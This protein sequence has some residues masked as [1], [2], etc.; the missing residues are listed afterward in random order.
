MNV[1]RD[2][3]ICSREARRG[4]LA[5]LALAAGLAAPEAAVAADP[6]RIIAPERTIVPGDAGIPPAAGAPL[7]LDLDL[8]A[9]GDDVVVFAG[10]DGYGGAFLDITADGTLYAAHTVE[11]GAGSEIRVLRSFDGGTTWA[12]WTSL[13]QP[14]TIHL[15]DF[16]IAEGAVDRA[17]VA[18]QRVASDFAAMFAA[19][20]LAD[21]SGT[22]QVR[23]LAAQPDY[24]VGSSLDLV[25]DDRDYSQYYLY[26]VWRR[27]GFAGSGSEVR[28]SRSLDGGNA[29]SPAIVLASQA[30]GSGTAVTRPHLAYVAGGWITVAYETFQ[31][32]GTDGGIYLR[33]APDFASGGLAAWQPAQTLDAPGNGV[34]LGLELHAGLP[35]PGSQ[36]VLRLNVIEGGLYGAPRLWYSTDA[37]AT[38]PAGQRPQLPLWT[39]DPGGGSGA[40]VASPATGEVIAAGARG[41]ASPPTAEIGIARSALDG[42]DG[43]SPLERFSSRVDSAWVGLPWLALDPSRGHR[44]AV[45]WSAVEDGVFQVLF[46]AEWRRDAGYPNLEPG[47]PWTPPVSLPGQCP[48]ALADLDLDGDLEI[49]VASP[50]GWVCVV[51]HDGTTRPGWPVQVPTGIP[52]DAPVAVGDLRANGQPAIVVGSMSGVVH[53]F[54]RDGQPLPGWPVATGDPAPTYVSIGALW[55][56]HPRYVVAVGGNTMKALTPGGQDASP[57]WGTFVETFGRPAAIGD[58]DADGVTEI[59]TAKGSTLHIHSLAQNTNENFRIFSGELLTGA[60]TLA[61]VD[62]DGDLEIAL[63]TSAGKLY[64]VHHDGSDYSADWPLTVAPGSALTEAAIVDMLGNTAPELLLASRGGEVH[65]RVLDGGSQPAYPKVPGGTIWM[66]PAADRID[67]TSPNT[68]IGSAAGLAWSWQNTGDVPGGWPRALAGESFEETPAIGDIDGDGRNEVVLHGLSRLWVFDVG[69]APHPDPRARWPMYQY[70]AQRTGCL[71]CPEEIPTGVPEG[72][73][74]TQVRFAAPWPNPASADAFFRFALPAEAEVAL[75]VYDVRGR[76]LQTVTEGTLPAGEH[77][78]AWNGRDQTGRRVAMG[79][80]L[81]RLIIASGPQAGVWTQKVTLSR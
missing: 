13:A 9:G 3:R 47:F 34:R 25:T 21:P 72:A 69:T 7:A 37:G 52:V 33:R 75:Q 15:E 29:W 43:W 36:A 26:A 30:A 28:F 70:D 41:F 53:A 73:V 10:A 42:L 23:T 81:A 46:D 4:L 27:G 60:P 19:A 32:D 68:V 35:G 40:L 64:L 38:W 76:L 17:C 14:G 51:E 54:D 80:Y 11:A 65:L 66:P 58:V 49:V 39:P 55:P 57:N 8:E 61:D 6:D 5:A 48:P 71:D 56:D 1:H 45:I 50:T 22:W 74:P 31:E 67:R 20:D 2:R 63:P 24:E 59:V 12:P 79:L 16:L 62:F 18:F 77:T 78:L 44:A